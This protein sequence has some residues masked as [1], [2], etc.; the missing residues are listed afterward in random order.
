[1][2]HDAERR[3]TEQRET[4]NPPESNIQHPDLVLGIDGGGTQTQALLARGS[5]GE[6]LGRGLAGASNIQAVGVETGL[7]AISDSIRGAFRN[8]GLSE[9]SVAS[10]CMGL[11]G[12]DWDGGLD[13]IHD[14]AAKNSIAA[15]VQVAN[16]ATLLLAAG[17]P[18]GW[19]LAVIAGTGAIAFVKDAAGREGRCGGWGYLLGDE[20]SAYSIALAA[21]KAACRSFDGVEKP[22]ALVDCVVEKMKIGSI[23]A[24]IEAV[25][26]GAWDRT[27][28]AGLAP[29]VLEIAGNGDAVAVAIVRKEAEDLARTAVGAVNANGLPKRGLP[30]ALAG[31]VLTRSEMFRGL[32]L[33]SL[34]MAGIEPGPVNLVTDPALGAVKLAMQSGG[35][36]SPR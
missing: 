36:A 35:T 28:I 15:K 11:A 14:W 8:A 18:E 21:L 13:V 5:T 32:F 31:G 6:V 17:T 33:D 30:V 10:I 16:D 19:G 34:W 22:T 29:A 12:I 4:V 7:R 9:G 26:R 25:Y 2:N 3:A 27:A 1:L 20:G 24:I 23:P